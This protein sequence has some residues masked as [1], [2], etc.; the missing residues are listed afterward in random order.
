MLNL[1]LAEMVYT[2][3]QM[4]P[5]EAIWWF[6]PV[7]IGT[8]VAGTIIAVVASSESTDTKKTVGKSLG[9]LG[10]AGAGKTQFLRNLQGKPYKRC[11]EQTAGAEDFEDFVFNHKGREISICKGKDIGGNVENIK[12]YYEDFIKNR[13]ICIFMFDIKK[14]IE[15]EKYRKD[16]N[17]RLDFINRHINDTSHWAAIGTHV[18]QMKIEQGKSIINIVQGYIKDKPYSRLLSINFF[19]SNL[20]DQKDMDIII[21]K[22][23]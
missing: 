4:E 6:I 15:Q 16:V 23:F 2:A 12:Y 20:T 21:D 17:T 10:M 1:I 9:I 18:D 5:Q 3:N 14:Y 11:D 22:I 7:L 8:A 19:A 13:D